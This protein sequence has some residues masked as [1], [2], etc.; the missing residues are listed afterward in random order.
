MKNKRMEEKKKENAVDV[1][2]SSV[3]DVESVPPVEAKD[4]QK[5][6]WNC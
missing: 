4:G 2:L 3:P 6:T 1:L 5:C